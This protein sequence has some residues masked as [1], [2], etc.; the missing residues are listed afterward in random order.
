MILST[1]FQRAWHT[2]KNIYMFKQGRTL[3][4]ETFCIIIFF[5]EIYWNYQCF[6]CIDNQ[7]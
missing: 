5:I 2:K 6:P 4:I 7:S 1:L 3:F